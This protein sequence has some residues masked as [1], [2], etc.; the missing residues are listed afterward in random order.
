MEDFTWIVSDSDE[1]V[2]EI[3]SYIGL[4]QIILHKIIILL[5]LLVA[6]YSIANL[7]VVTILTT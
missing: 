7:Q 3:N 1:L 5:F 6:N 4:W 2:G